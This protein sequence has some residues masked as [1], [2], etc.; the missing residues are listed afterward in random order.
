VSEAV[1]PLSPT[2]IQAEIK[3]NKFDDLES[4]IE[5]F[6]DPEDAGS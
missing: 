4:M 1:K 6:Y 3:E 5:N 2:R